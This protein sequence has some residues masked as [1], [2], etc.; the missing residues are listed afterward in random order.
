MDYILSYI[1]NT[2]AVSGILYGKRWKF[3]FLS[4]AKAENHIAQNLIPGGA[5]YGQD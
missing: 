5:A 3:G 1:G 2:E 4:C